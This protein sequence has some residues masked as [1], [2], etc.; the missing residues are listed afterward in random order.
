MS[1]IT[2]I[3]LVDLKIIVDD[4]NDII[5]IRFTYL[6]DAFD[7]KHHVAEP[8]YARGHTLNL[9]MYQSTFIPND[10]IAGRSILSDHGLITRY[11]LLVRLT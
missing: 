9:I 3:I 11:F 7:L 8:T 5:T 1:K 6:L 10:D 4:T 2:T